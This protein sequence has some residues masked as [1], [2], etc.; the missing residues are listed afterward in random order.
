MYTMASNVDTIQFVV[1]EYENILSARVFEHNGYTVVAIL[2]GPIFSA[3]ERNS[4]KESVKEDVAT[5]IGVD[6]AKVIITFD[7]E[8]FRALDDVKS[9]DKDK[10]LAMALNRS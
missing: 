6:S 9:Q 3:T 5:T 4:L 8:L 7:M 2:T 10:L 1:F